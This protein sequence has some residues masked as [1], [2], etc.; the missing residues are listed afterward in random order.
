MISHKSAK[1]GN[2]DYLMNQNVIFFASAKFLFGKTEFFLENS[3]FCFLFLLQKFSR[4]GHLSHKV[5]SQFDE[6]WLIR[7]STETHRVVITRMN[8]RS[9]IF[10][11]KGFISVLKVCKLVR[12]IYMYFFGSF[13]KIY[14]AFKH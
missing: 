11:K 2:T 9:F 13:Y 8:A 12:F 3:E 4:R 14:F 10:G 1:V 6:I 7:Y 5:K